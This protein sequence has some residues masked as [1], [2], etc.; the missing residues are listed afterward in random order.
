M[1]AAQMVLLLLTYEYFT[2]TSIVSLE[3]Q[4]DVSCRLFTVVVH[5]L[6][7]KMVLLLQC[8]RRRRKEKRYND[9]YYIIKM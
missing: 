5:M 3:V 8:S 6:A 7:A 4:Y 2:L 1:L 9:L